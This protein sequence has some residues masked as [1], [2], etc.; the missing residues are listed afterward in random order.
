MGAWLFLTFFIYLHNQ[1]SSIHFTIPCSRVQMLKKVIHQIDSKNE[2]L[3]LTASFTA[4]C[5]FYFVLTLENS[6]SYRLHF[7]TNRKNIGSSKNGIRGFQ[8]SHPFERSACFY[9]TIS[10]NFKRFQCFN[11]ETDFLENKNPFQKPKVLF[12]S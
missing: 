10:G 2:W 7:K 4:K 9:V 1:L 6:F 12:F 5:R 8:N 11:F 3:L